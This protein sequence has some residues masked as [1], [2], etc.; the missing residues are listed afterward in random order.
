MPP[1]TTDHY[2]Y[3]NSTLVTSDIAD[4]IPDLISLFQRVAIA[5]FFLR[6]FGLE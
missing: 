4:W 5:L 6:L 3:L 1:N 2:D